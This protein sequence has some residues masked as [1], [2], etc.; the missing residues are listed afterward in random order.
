MSTT[1]YMPRVAFDTLAYAN[2]LKEAGLDPRIAE[3][4]AELQATI[5]T[6]LTCNQLATKKD[7]QDLKFE[8]LLKLG[9]IVIACTTILGILFTILSRVH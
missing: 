1:N 5:L 2:K 8:L 6:D 3:A 4:Q 9:G 7:M